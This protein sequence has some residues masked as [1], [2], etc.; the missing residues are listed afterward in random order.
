MS[1]FASDIPKKLG[2]YE[3]TGILGRGAM[4]VVYKAYDPL[5]ARHVAL[6]AI[7]KDLIGQESAEQA[8]VRFRNE[9]MAAGR[10]THPGIVAVYD[11]G[12]D[13][14]TA[15]IAME[16]AEGQ[17]LREYLRARGAIKLA[18]I[19]QMM[20]QLL[21]A[22]DYAHAR[23]VVHR[24]VKPGNIIVTTEGK[25][26]VTDFGIARLDTT[27]L[28]QTGM[29]VGT[30]SYMSP[31]Q[32]TGLPVD[33]RTDLFAAGVMLYEMILGSKPFSGGHEAVAYQIC[34]EPHTPPSRIDAS[35]PK[36]LDTLMDKALAKKK[37]QRF[38]NA[39]E[40]SRALQLA[41]TGGG[42]AEATM[43]ATAARPA[44][45]VGET[46]SLPMGWNPESLRGLEDALIPFIGPVARTL[47]KRGAAKSL[48]AAALIEVLVNT[49]DGPEER[50]LFTRKARIIL[51]QTQPENPTAIANAATIVAHRGLPEP[52]LTLAAMRLTPLVGPIAK[53]LV[54][55]AATQSRTLEQLYAELAEHITDPN[56][57]ATFLKLGAQKK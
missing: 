39:A 37:E 49:L 11:Y 34:H 41:L 9:A 6:K 36:S 4:G 28:T 23:G 20:S 33:H 47:V 53:V 52:D 32:Y 57:K 3:I 42:D 38:A 7:R 13:G 24:D 21:D 56:D 55:R 50:A 5:I 16:Y 8:V 1:Q 22:L 29:I 15:Y 2:K 14:P 27:N 19:G 43:I 48:D 18:E 12:E 17:G 30:P 25:L 10:L 31:E 26:K 44:P 54:K 40:F 45:L 35:L 51:D 46:T